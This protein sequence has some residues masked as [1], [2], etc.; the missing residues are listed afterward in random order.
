MDSLAWSVLA[1]L[2]GFTVG[3]LFGCAQTARY[4]AGKAGGEP[5]YRTAAYHAGKFYYV[6]R[7]G[8]REWARELAR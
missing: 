3:H 2:I 6:V 4:W 8:D 1:G 7:E 5:A